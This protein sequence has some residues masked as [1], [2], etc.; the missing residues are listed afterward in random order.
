MVPSQYSIQRKVFFH[1][2]IKFLADNWLCIRLLVRCWDTDWDKIHTGPDT[3]LSNKYLDHNEPSRKFNWFATIDEGL[4]PLPQCSLKF[5][6]LN[7]EK[8]E[9]KCKINIFFYIFQDITHYT[10]HDNCS[11]LPYLV[12]IEYLTMHLVLYMNYLHW[13]F[14]TILPRN[15]CTG[16]KK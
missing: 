4:L 3:T 1:S 6:G 5:W 7:G 10:L 12:F 8:W 14:I 11:K 15:W 2:L 13:L 9:M 16:C